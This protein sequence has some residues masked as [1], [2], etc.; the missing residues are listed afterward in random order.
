LTGV[1]GPGT[2]VAAVTAPADTKTAL[3]EAATETADIAAPQPA[4]RETPTGGTTRPAV[5]SPAGS[6]ATL[7]VAPSG[8]E[9]PKMTAQF[10]RQLVTWALTGVG[11]AVL[12]VCAGSLLIRKRG[13]HNPA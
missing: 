1:G 8:E 3:A 2:E 13:P 11:L 10:N 5:S 6:A 7:A 4:A 9:L 12:L